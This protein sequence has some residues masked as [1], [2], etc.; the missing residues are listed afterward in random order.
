MYDVEGITI[1]HTGINCLPAIKLFV[2]RVHRCRAATVERK[3]IIGE[4]LKTSAAA[5][6]QVE[7]VVAPLIP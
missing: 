3:N 5:E 6:T 4:Y 2:D 7:A 1:Q